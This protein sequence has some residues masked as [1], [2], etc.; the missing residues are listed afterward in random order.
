MAVTLSSAEIEKL[1]RAMQLLLTPLAHSSVDAWRSAVNHQLKELLHADSAGFFLPVANGPALYSEEHDPAEL[2][3]YTDYLPPPLP[4]GRLIYELI[5]HTPVSPI[6]QVYGRDYDIYLKSPYYNEYAGKNGAHD[7]LFMSAPV[8]ARESPIPLAL[9]HLWHSRPDG[10]LFGER[11]LSLLRLLHP[12]FRAGV[13]MHLHLGGQRG[14][15][16]DSLD[17]L[18]VAAV[19]YDRDGELIH[20]TPALCAI[21][22]ADPE[23][24][25]LR[26][27][28]VAVVGRALAVLRGGGTC[29]TTLPTGPVV[30]EVRT[31]TAT[32]LVR[33]TLHRDPA[34]GPDDVVLGV[35]ERLTP[36]PRSDDELRATFGLT[37]A[38]LR[39]ARL[40]AQGHANAEIAATLHISPHTARHHTERILFK[41]EIHSRA[42]VG[43]KLFQ[44]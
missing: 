16:V 33:A 4:D 9:I 25:R 13:E 18:G 21:L 23:A 12:A 7:T 31:A 27:E 39:V 19:L 6:S 1:A 32:Y 30:S 42:E 14:R 8:I 11:E 34:A 10:N 2:A 15:L 35:L 22:A 36:M 37:R 43:P 3:R 38:E 28:L 17:A 44:K 40:L 29:A 41:L 5:V 24:D 26:N 20:K